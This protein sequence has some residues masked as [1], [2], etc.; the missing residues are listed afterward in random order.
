MVRGKLF[1]VRANPPR[2]SPPAGRVS[3]ILVLIP[4]LSFYFTTSAFGQ[5][6]APSSVSSTVQ[7]SAASLRRGTLNPAILERGL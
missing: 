1:P 6:P 2:G 4:I 7:P 3:S 5:G